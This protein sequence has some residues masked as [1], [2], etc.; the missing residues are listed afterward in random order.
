[1]CYYFDN[2]SKYLAKQSKDCDAKLIGPVRWQPVARTYNVTFISEALY[3]HI[4]VGIM[5][6]FI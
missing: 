2:V 4:R 3:C 6:L 5:L 1:M